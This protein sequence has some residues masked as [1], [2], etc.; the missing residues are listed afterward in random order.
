MV[1]SIRP[2][3]AGPVTSPADSLQVQL[4]ET[5]LHSQPEVARRGQ[6]FELHIHLV[7]G[8]PGGE[9]AV[10]PMWKDQKDLLLLET[11]Y[12]C[13]TTRDQP[14]G[15][16]AMHARLLLRLVATREGL[17]PIDTLRV[18][19][20]RGSLRRVV[21]FAP[22]AIRVLPPVSLWPRTWN[23]LAFGAGLAALGIGIFLSRRG[24]PRK[25]AR[26][27]PASPGQVADQRLRVLEL[28]PPTKINVDRLIEHIRLES[29]RRHGGAWTRTGEAAFQA[30]S[31][32]SD[33]SEAVRAR[34]GA[35]ISHLEARRYLPQEPDAATWQQWMSEA[36]RLWDADEQIVPPAPK[37]P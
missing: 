28:S 15:R 29:T 37:G 33:A 21:V 24:R 8:S 11:G 1:T 31:A 36:R 25:G 26:T 30:W 22:T 6:P 10:L 18:A 7:W 34:V 32:S 23:L 17:V 16:Y 14:G 27:A 12:E 5:A 9:E 19:L 35:L 2:R 4:W 3:A 20:A 13:R